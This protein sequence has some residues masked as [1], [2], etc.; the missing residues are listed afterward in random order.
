MMSSCTSVARWIS[1]TVTARSICCGVDFPLRM[2][3]QKHQRG[4][5]PLAIAVERITHITRNSRIEFLHLKPQPL[6][7]NV[8]VRLHRGNMPMQIELLRQRRKGPGEPIAKKLRP[9]G[10][11]DFWSLMFRNLR[12]PAMRVKPSE[13]YFH[14]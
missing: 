9:G 12:L 1:S 7:D 3:R 6:L 2:R 4:P 13:I 5:N 10:K 8:E 11:R 14:K